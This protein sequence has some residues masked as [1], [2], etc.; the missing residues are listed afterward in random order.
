M[1]LNL[2]VK[3]SPVNSI[4]QMMFPGSTVLIRTTQLYRTPWQTGKVGYLMG[5]FGDIH[6]FDDQQPVFGYC[7]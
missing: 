6:G 5:P 4:K 7:R 3:V 1:F 2:H